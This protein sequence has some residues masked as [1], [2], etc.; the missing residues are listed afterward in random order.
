MDVKTPIY[1]EF[2]CMEDFGKAL[3]DEVRKD[4]IGEDVKLWKGDC[5]V[6]LFQHNL[7]NTMRVIMNSKRI[8]T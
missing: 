4:T 6:T 1:H 2:K 8:Y 7:W 3:L 5:G